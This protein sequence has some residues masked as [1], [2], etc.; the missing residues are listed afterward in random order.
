MWQR[1]TRSLLQQR[2]IRIQNLWRNRRSAKG[3]MSCPLYV[4]VWIQQS[5]SRAY[6]MCWETSI[7][8]KSNPCRFLCEFYWRKSLHIPHDYQHEYLNGIQYQDT[9]P[10]DEKFSSLVSFS[11]RKNISLLIRREV[12]IIRKDKNGDFI[13]VRRANYSNNEKKLHH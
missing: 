4:P 7:Q 11:D 10:G 6:E 13:R 2:L 3:W 8:A 1:Q 12:L 9:T 5:L